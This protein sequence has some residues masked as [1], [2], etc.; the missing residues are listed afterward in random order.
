MGQKYSTTYNDANFI[1]AERLFKLSYTLSKTLKTFKS[2]DHNVEKV[3]ISRVFEK[4]HHT[5]GVFMQFLYFLTKTSGYTLKPTRFEWGYMS[6]EGILHQIN[7][8]GFPVI[9]ND[10]IKDIKVIK[11][12]YKPDL[13]VIYYFL[14]R[15]RPLLAMVILEPVFITECLKLSS[16]NLKDIATDAVIIVGYDDISFSIK[17]NWFDFIV[18]VENKFIDNFKELWDVS[19]KT[20]Y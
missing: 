20:H 15:G 6:I 10:Y 4:Y 17:T 13:N 12:C 11:D 9:N 16:E 14:S 18:N 2:Q 3:D 19:L 1:P 5:I 8:N 7:M